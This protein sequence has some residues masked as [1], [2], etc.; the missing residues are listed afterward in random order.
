MSKPKLTP[1]QIDSMLSNTESAARG[2]EALLSL[3]DQFED[4]ELT[5]PPSER[6][7]LDD[8]NRRV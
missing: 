4:E 1:E 6:D 8:L 2:L 3:Q 7:Q 5:D